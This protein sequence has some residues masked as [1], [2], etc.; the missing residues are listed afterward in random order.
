MEGMQ[1]GL[2]LCSVV[3]VAVCHQPYL[4]GEVPVPAGAACW[5]LHRHLLNLLAD[6]S[7]DYGVTVRLLSLLGEFVCA[8]TLPCTQR[9]N[10]T[11]LL[12]RRLPGAATS[13]VNVLIGTL[14][15]LSADPPSQ[16]LFVLF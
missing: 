9:S 6:A 16:C 15:L 11:G 14:K 5:A 10:V 7:L 4:S 12:L 13:H 3:A 2:A 1:V 8:H